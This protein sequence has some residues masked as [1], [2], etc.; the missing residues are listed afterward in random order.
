MVLQG[1]IS[2]IYGVV[3]SSWIVAAVALKYILAIQAVHA[4]RSEGGF[5]ENLGSEIQEF[6][7][8]LVT[9]IILLGIAVSILDINFSA[10]FPAFSYAIAAVYFG[11]LFWEF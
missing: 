1:V 10:A 4:Y 2:F 7:R 8:E 11:Y 5:L 6:S 3:Q 9:I